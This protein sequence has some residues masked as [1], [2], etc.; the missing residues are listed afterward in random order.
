MNCILYLHLSAFK[1]LIEFLDFT[2]TCSD[3]FFFPWY[4]ITK[5]KNKQNSSAAVSRKSLVLR[6]VLNFTT[7][8]KDVILTYNWNCLQCLA[9]RVLTAEFL[10]LRQNKWH[11]YELCFLFILTFFCPICQKEH[12]VI[13]SNSFNIWISKLKML[14][15]MWPSL[16]FQ[17]IILNL[18]QKLKEFQETFHNWPLLETSGTFVATPVRHKT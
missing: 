5:N 13:A 1:W 7:I 8:H 16:L 9:A 17:A 10:A 18:M 2:W 11:L 3:L 15:V 12:I 14:R 4:V 6:E